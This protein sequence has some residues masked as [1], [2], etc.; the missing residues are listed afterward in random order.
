MVLLSTGADQALE[1]GFEGV[2]TL[3]SKGVHRWFA[4]DAGSRQFSVAADG[5]QT[6]Q[7][8]KDDQRR[9]T[10]REIKRAEE[11]AQ[12]QHQALKARGRESRT[13]Y[14]HALFQNYGELFS[15][16]IN[17]FLSRKLIDPYSAGRHHQAWEFLLHFCNR[18]PRSIA[19]IALTCVIDRISTISEKGKLGIV[20]GRALQDELNGTVVHDE[21]G[22]VL[23]SV[24]KKKFG[25]KTVSAKVMNK[26]KVSPRGVDHAGEA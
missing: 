10:E 12:N 19:V 23:L 25:R 17:V 20:I 1:L 7:N 13:S 14:G 8:P 9:R 18:G 2:T 26:L 11:R 6:G 5:M 21:R 24:V 4:L 15:Q 22:M 3:V 16:G